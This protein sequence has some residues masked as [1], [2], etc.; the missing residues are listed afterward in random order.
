MIHSDFPYQ[1][2]IKA[3][4][5]V[6]NGD[7]A[8]T[9]LL[10]RRSCRAYKPDLPERSDL[11]RLFRVATMAPAAFN[12]EDRGFVFVTDPKVL[13]A[14]RTGLVDVTKRNIK[15]LSVFITKPLSFL[16]PAATI[17]HFKRM[18][19]DFNRYHYTGAPEDN[20][21]ANGI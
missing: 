11:E 18:I 20:L 5:G 21:S 16:L 19:F 17:E 10:S 9:M 12:C 4:P 15:L 8:E 14:L 3:Q 6:V 1:E 2:L 13:G 7:D